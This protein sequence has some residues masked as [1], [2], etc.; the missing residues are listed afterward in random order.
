MIESK[1]FQ[2]TICRFIELYGDR[3]EGVGDEIH[4]GLAWIDKTKF[5]L[6]GGAD[7]ATLYPPSWRRVSRL[8]D[9]AEQ[10]HRPVLLWDVPFQADTANPTGTLLHRSA[11]Q[12]SQL[13]L[14]KLPVPIIGVFDSL[15]LQPEFASVDAAILVQQGEAASQPKPSQYPPSPIL[16]KVI[17]DP[18]HLKLDILELLNHLSTLPIERLVDQRLNSIRQAVGGVP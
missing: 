5:V 8:F 3:T 6:I 12:N 7:T 17:D 4:A 13:H 15:P 1:Q 11:A 2:N 16:V 14:L 10:L 9:L 18:S